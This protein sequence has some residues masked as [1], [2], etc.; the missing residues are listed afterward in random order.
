[1]ASGRDNSVP[2]HR[3]LS[4]FL[5]LSATP[6]KRRDNGA[7]DE[8]H[9]I[10]SVH[11]DL[12][13]LASN[14]SCHTQSTRVSVPSH[15]ST[16]SSSSTHSLT[17]SM[18]TT[19]GYPDMRYQPRYG[20]P[21]DMPRYGYPVPYTAEMPVLRHHYNKTV[22]P[23]P[24]NLDLTA[25][26]V[27]ALQV[28]EPT[29]V[30]INVPNIASP[31]GTLPFESDNE[32]DKDE[33]DLPRQNPQRPTH[34]NIPEKPRHQGSGSST[35]DSDSIMLAIILYLQHQNCNNRKYCPCCKMIT[36]QFE[37]IAREQGQDTFEK[38]MKFIQTPG[39][40]G[41]KQMLRRRGRIPRSPSNP[42]LTLGSNLKRHRSS[43]TSKIHGKELKFSSSESEEDEK[44]VRKAQHP[45]KVHTDN[46]TDNEMEFFL[47]LNSI[48]NASSEPD[49]TRPTSSPATSS[50]SSITITP[51]QPCDTNLTGSTSKSLL[52]TTAGTIVNNS[53]MTMR[54]QLGSKDPQNNSKLLSSETSKHHDYSSYS[55]GYETQSKEEKIPP[56]SISNYPPTHNNTLLQPIKSHIEFSDSNSYRKSSSYHPQ[57]IAPH[58][59]DQRAPYPMDSMSQDLGDAERNSLKQEIIG[60]VISSMHIILLTEFFVGEYNKL[61]TEKDILIAK[62]LK[63]KSQLKEELQS[64]KDISSDIK[65]DYL[66]KTGNVKKTGCFSYSCSIV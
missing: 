60:K 10:T 57:S 58:L 16:H 22:V 6:G 63:E 24:T 14:Y 4:Q 32:L 51:S 15:S 45:H 46:E 49:L 18:D 8:N 9:E 59:S 19:S 37:K 2:W 53:S 26:Q 34:L 40:E 35:P 54:Q 17:T 11:S 39:T 36:K 41:H 56:L 12:G 28:Q 29:P 42:G 61:I 7:E 62:L 20:Y 66:A 48:M 30:M 38:A 13:D 5:R 50:S 65:C 52:L 23:P 21:D 33:G 44:S 25:K 64:L 27:P 43:S 55:S 3:R 31:T 47:P 1:M